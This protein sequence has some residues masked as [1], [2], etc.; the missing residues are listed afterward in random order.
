MQTNAPLDRI[1]QSLLTASGSTFRNPAATYYQIEPD[2]LKMAENTAQV[3]MGM[4][5]QCAQCH[6]HPFDRW[7]LNDYYSFAALLRADWPQAGRR[8]ARDRHL[9]PPR[10]RGEASGH[11][12]RHAP[13]IPR[14]RGARHQGR[15]P[16]RGAGPLADLAAEPVFRAQCREHHLGPFPGPRHHR[17]GGRRAHQQSALQPGAARRPGGPAH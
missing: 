2:T 16:P 12:R 8:P 7:T 9:R 13:E 1:V 3:F 10:R 5:I 17:A 14:R 4:R 6:N 11:P 15:E